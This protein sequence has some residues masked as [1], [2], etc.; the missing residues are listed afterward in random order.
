MAMSIALMLALFLVNALLMLYTRSVLQHAADVGARSGARSGGT[1]SA[2][3]ATVTQ[4]I[5]GLASLYAESVS[6]ECSR[7]TLATIATVTADL[8]PV[9]SGLGPAWELTVR[10]ASATEPVP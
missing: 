6:V 3:E 1:E 2:C 5:E 7:E 8:E 9:F 10:A 4:T